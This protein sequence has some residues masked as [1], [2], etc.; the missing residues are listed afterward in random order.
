MTLACMVV[1]VLRQGVLAAQLA[2][3]R[4]IDPIRNWPTFDNAIRSFCRAARL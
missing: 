2:A 1:A 3:S 4:L